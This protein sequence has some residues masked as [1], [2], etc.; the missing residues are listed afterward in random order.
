MKHAVF[1]HPQQQ[2]LPFIW[3]LISFMRAESLHLNHFPKA[4]FLIV[5]SEL[6]V[7]QE[8]WGEPTII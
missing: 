5:T 1:P 6:K 2:L 7:Q 3:V 4:I 8:F